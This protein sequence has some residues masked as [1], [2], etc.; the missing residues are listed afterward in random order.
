MF[1]TSAL[2][3]LS[4]TALAAHAYINYANDF[5][6]PA[7]VLSKNFSDTTKPAQA[8]ILAWADESDVG[9]P[10]CEYDY[11]FGIYAS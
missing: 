10:W 11:F 5:I 3:T 1:R 8:T 2:F 9:S 7:Y 4:F 6:D